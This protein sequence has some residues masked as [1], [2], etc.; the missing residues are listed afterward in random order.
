MLGKVAIEAPIPP[1]I[2]LDILVMEGDSIQD[3][4]KILHI[5]TPKG[6]M[7]VT[8]DRSG[9]VRKV[10][11][12]QYDLLIQGLDILHVEMNE[13]EAT[14]DEEDGEPYA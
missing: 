14:K 2:I 1:S 6:S 9:T 8:T 5:L 11:V 13:E 12:E 4:D 3:G 10:L 7:G